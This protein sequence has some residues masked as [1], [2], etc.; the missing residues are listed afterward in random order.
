MMLFAPA[1]NMKPCVCSFQHHPLS[2]HSWPRLQAL[3]VLKP[4]K[5][6][7]ECLAAFFA[8][9]E[10]YEW[11]V[12]WSFTPAVICGVFFNKSCFI[13]KRADKHKAAVWAGLKVMMKAHPASSLLASFAPL[14]MLEMLCTLCVS[15][16]LS[17]FMIFFPSLCWAHS[18]SSQMPKKS[19]SWK[20]ELN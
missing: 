10:S 1:C 18:L 5:V 17:N 12:S 20:L 19:C 13:G 11:A 16:P 14:C 9:M 2:L 7:T 4:S 15:S 3:M 6:D 8:V